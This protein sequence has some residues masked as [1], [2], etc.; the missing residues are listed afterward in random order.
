M[1]GRQFGTFPSHPPNCTVTVPSLFFCAVM[2][3]TEYAS[4]AFF[5]KYPFASYT[6]IDQKPSTGTLPTVTLYK[7]TPSLSGTFKGTYFASR[8]GFP[9]QPDAAPTRCCSGSVCCF[10]PNA[11]EKSTI[12]NASAPNASR[13]LSWLALSHF[14]TS[15]FPAFL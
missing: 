5:T 13:T 8:S 9:P 3:F 1:I 6:L 11:F 12:V 2:L 10:V 14:G 7:C 15:K 4:Y